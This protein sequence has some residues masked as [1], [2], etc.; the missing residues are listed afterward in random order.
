MSETRLVLH[1]GPAR[2]RL[3]TRCARMAEAFRESPFT[4]TMLP[5]YRAEPETDEPCLFTVLLEPDD[6]TALTLTPLEARFQF[7][8]RAP[9]DNKEIYFEVLFFLQTWFARRLLQDH[10]IHMLKA[11]L[12]AHGGR[13][14][15]IS[16]RSGAGKSSVL[17]ACLKRLE[18]A[19]SCFFDGKV[20]CT[21]D[22][23]VIGGN[24][25]LSSRQIV[26]GG[27]P[28]VQKRLV[29][30]D[31]APLPLEGLPISG[32]TCV[33]IE[34]FAPPELFTCAVYP[35]ARAVGHLFQAGAFYPAGQQSHLHFFSQPLPFLDDES[36]V[37]RRYAFARRLAEKPVWKCYG[38][39]ERISSW[40]IDEFFGLGDPIQ[41]QR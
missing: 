17:A 27:E 40:V 26:P 32:T 14:L 20:L 24:L 31:A 25:G 6:R 36:T 22:L 21:E 8:E 12:I 19:G 28:Q 15:L 33:R 38:N 10:G 3:I 11:A 18:L 23:R 13:N 2:L 35:P 29:M 5:S 7:H 4:G 39:V 34:A 30:L 9:T 16:G 1:C 37:R 41:V